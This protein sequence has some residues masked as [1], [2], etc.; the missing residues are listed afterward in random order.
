MGNSPVELKE[1]RLDRADMKISTVLGMTLALVA[2][3][4]AAPNWS[5]WNGGGLFYPGSGGSGGS[6]YPSNGASGGSFYPGGNNNYGGT[7]VPASTGQ[8]RHHSKHHWWGK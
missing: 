6:F 8:R 7:F 4:K 5:R 3:A 1:A 2:L